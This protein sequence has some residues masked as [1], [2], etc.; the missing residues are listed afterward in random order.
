MTTAKTK[1]LWGRSP[2]QNTLSVGHLELAEMQG[3]H[4]AIVGDLILDHYVTGEVERISPEAPVPILRAYSERYVAGGA[5]N[6]AANVA[7]LG[8]HATLL[9]V[10][11]DDSNA[12]RL[13]DTLKEHKGVR[14]QLF[15]DAG[16]RTPT[17]TRYLGQRQQILRVDKEDLWPVE[18]ELQERILREL[19]DILGTIGALILSDYSKGLLTAEF[20][21]TVIA[22]CESAGVPTIVD[23]KKLDFS[24]YRGTTYITPNRK[25]LQGAT[26]LPCETDIDAEVAAQRAML[27]S[28]ASVLLTRSEL[29]MSFFGLNGTTLHMPTAAIEVFDVSGAGDTVVAAFSLALAARLGVNQAMQI[30][31][32]AAGVT[33]SKQGTATATQNEL[34]RMMRSTESIRVPFEIFHET[35]ALALQCEEWRQKGL[36]IGFANGCFDLLHPGHIKLLQSAAMDCDKLVVALNSDSSVRRIKG[37]NRPVQNEAARAEVMAS[38]K[39]VNAVTFFDEETPLKLIHALKPD[40]IFKGSDYTIDEVVGGEFVVA[41][42]GRV[43]IV[44][45]KKGESTS[46]IVRMSTD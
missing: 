43:C 37:P 5:A 46:R 32:L 2:K 27:D 22:K 12:Q 11:G 38:I 40:V 8:G 17:K 31:N 18:K 4:V 15:E 23:P 36:S 10:V 35:R 3:K 25:E 7:S 20:L 45:L 24:F 21:E 33:V 29:G 30:A 19:D 16:R 39:G 9:G 34:A 44:E 14:L 6:V 41:N 42:G 1:S 28:D 26:G 13:R